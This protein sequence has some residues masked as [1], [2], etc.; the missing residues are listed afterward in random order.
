M[1][2]SDINLLVP[3][4]SV[5]EEFI[6]P[7][8]FEV[9]RDSYM[10]PCSHNFCKECIMECLNRKKICPCCNA[11]ATPQQLVPNKQFD[12]VITILIA[13]KDKAS[14]EYFDALISGGGIIESNNQKVTLSPIET[15]L[16]GHMQKHIRYYQDYQTKLEAH[17]KTRKQQIKEK[18]MGLLK[19]QTKKEQKRRLKTEREE[20]YSEL[21]IIREQ[22][23]ELIQKT[24]DKYLKEFTV[25]S[26]IFPV[27]V[28]LFIPHK[29]EHIKY[30]QINPI[31]TS[32]TLKSEISK[33]MESKGDPILS[34]EKVNIFVLVQN[35]NDPGIPITDDSIRII[36]TYNP[37]PGS[38]FVLQGHLK[39]AKDAPKKCYKLVHPTL[40]K[41]VPID[42][43]TCRTC[44]L[45]WICTTCVE[46]CHK[47]HDVQSFH[48]NH[49]PTWACCYCQKKK[50]TL[51][52]K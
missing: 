51:I 32:T 20:K 41:V 11:A 23:A 14:K 48:L 9:I 3:V 27:I 43:F 8:C 5:S 38:I 26:L 15:A 4:N 24:L 45:N 19:E 25:P 13:E 30:I 35:D 10:T 1:D 50:C 49:L 12:R 18:Y 28:H 6:C 7:I 46:C 17:I 42:Y 2:D 22:S 44:T 52:A 33:H 16:L 34:F 47:G 29:S 21:T 31:D 37:S 40:E 36:E 39:C